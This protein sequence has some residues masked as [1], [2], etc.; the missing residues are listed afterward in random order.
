MERLIRLKGAANVRDLGGYKTKDGRIVLHQ[1]LIRAAAIGELTDADSCQLSEYGVT[2]IVDFRSEKEKRE[3][4]DRVIAGAENIFLPI[5]SE[6]AEASAAPQD[7]FAQIQNG[8]SA[9]VAMQQV[10]RQFVEKEH[11]RKSY[12]RFLDI[13]LENDRKS[14]SVL[15]HCTAGKDRT[16]FGAALILLILG[17]DK[18]QI[19]E[20]YLA[21]NLNLA[22]VTKKLLEDA[23][24]QGADDLLVAEIKE[25][26]SANQQFLDASFAAMTELYGT[27][28]QFLTQGLAVDHTQRE[29]FRQLYLN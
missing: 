19:R 10:Y 6:E 29:L 11:S 28:E 22:P 18:Q 23:R 26:M 20:N 27:P 15:F 9:A 1:K 2:R 13:L 7:L 24:R 8:Q 3:R 21:T 16:G 17:V 14:S 12:R 5:F 4:P 25:L